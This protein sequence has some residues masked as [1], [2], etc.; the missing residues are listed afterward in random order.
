MS[1]LKSIN[2]RIWI[3]FIFIAIIACGF[4]PFIVGD[5]F[6]VY[7]SYGADS[8][9]S[10]WPLK[11]ISL[12]WL[13]SND[14]GGW[15]WELGLGTNIFAIQG[16]LFD[17]FNL[18]LLPFNSRF[19]PIGFL[20]TAVL[21]FG[22][23]GFMF[24]R[25]MILRGNSNNVSAL[26]ALILTFNG[27]AVL[28]S[29]LDANLTV[30][31]FIIGILFGYEYFRKKNKSFFLVLFVALLAANSPY[32]TWMAG[33]FFIVYV[34][35]DS[36]SLSLITKSIKHL[37]KT[38]IWVI[39]GVSLVGIL[40]IPGVYILFDNPRLTGGVLPS[41][42]PGSIADYTG[43]ILRGINTNI[44]PAEF[45][46]VSYFSGPLWTTSIIVLIT[47]PQ[48]FRKRFHSKT[49]AIIMSICFLSILFTN[50]T[51]PLFNGFSQ[52]TYRW[53]WFLI[54]PI[55]M[56]AAKVWSSWESGQ[57]LSGKLLWVGWS[58]ITILWISGLFYLNL[59]KKVDLRAAGNEAVVYSNIFLA[60]LLLAI[61]M[62][63]ILRERVNKK[64]FAT[65]ITILVAVELAFSTSATLQSRQPM[66]SSDFE[67]TY[68]DGTQ[69]AVS[70]IAKLEEDRSFYRIDK[71][72]QSVFLDDAPIQG[73]KGVKSYLSSNNPAYFAFSEIMEA[74]PH[75]NFIYGFDGRPNIQS[76]LGVHY[77]ISRNQTEVAGY[78]MIGQ[79]G[80]LYIYENVHSLPLG[81]VYSNRLLV[82]EF[83]KLDVGN[84]ELAILN[85]AIVGKGMAT[86]LPAVTGFFDPEIAIS[87]LNESPL[88]PNR[89]DRSHVS[90]EVNIN[91][92][93]MLFLSVPYDRGWKAWIDETPTQVKNINMGF[94]GLEVAPGKHNVELR[95]VPPG[96][97]VGL[98]VTS[99]VGLV[100]LLRYIYLKLISKRK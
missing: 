21:K 66:Q 5:K 68:Y 71:D 97:Y 11:H 24:Y 28:W 32:Y 1:Y 99:A 35:I 9:W 48:L 26:T 92:Q 74:N 70:Q 61:V 13:R 34:L 43:F 69:E 18:F 38:A 77:L 90:G 10:Y 56:G 2:Y 67:T 91:E 93:G 37:L 89:I 44:L 58:S 76:L 53:S 15:L 84:K 7:K 31:V 14:K 64:T 78:Q 80:N 12:D 20:I 46:P 23:A 50:I 63:I 65:L 22:I 57:P 39:C 87:K 47:L 4:L 59:I 8:L 79:E 42:I 75:Y 41:L 36:F 94:I 86:N 83:M 52:E 25:C 16:T 3:F 45:V 29:C 54:I 33:L 72:Y 60:C 98:W 27:Y 81:F 85:A 73:F 62:I 100:L 96:F 51:I 49:M 19:I 55:L 17:P 82:D 95:Y 6:F 88:V 40:F 30:Y